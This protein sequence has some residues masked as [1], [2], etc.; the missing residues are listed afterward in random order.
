VVDAMEEADVSVLFTDL[1][2]SESVADAIAA[3]TG[4]E[5]VR[6]HP[7]QLPAGGSY[8]E[9]MRELAQAIS[10]ALAS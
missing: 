6:L 8:V 10:G 2:T 5:V 3:E 9:F 1:G 4:A 7:A